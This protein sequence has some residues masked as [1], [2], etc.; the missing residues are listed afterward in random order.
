MGR[1][2]MDIV[3]DD[4][5]VDMNYANPGSHVPEIERNNKTVKE[6]FRAQYHQLPYHNIPKIMI[7]YLAMEVVR[8][9]KFF[10][11]KGGIPPYYSP[12]TVV[13]Q[14]PLKF[15]HCEIPFGAFV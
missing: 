8:K 7:K 9:L 2:L 10:Q 4:L 6:R 1:L 5:Q 3:K 15:H 14:K 13:E 12:K 11:V